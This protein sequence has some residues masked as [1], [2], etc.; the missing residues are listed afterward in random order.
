MIN[1]FKKIQRNFIIG[2][3]WL[4][5]KIY[6]GY[7]TSDKIIRETIAPLVE[8]LFKEKLIDRWFFIRYTDPKY[9]L[10]IRIHIVDK[11][12]LSDVLLIFNSAIRQYLEDDL[13]SKVQADTYQREIERYGTT[14]MELSEEIFCIDSTAIINLI[15]NLHGT[16][17][18]NTRWLIT[19]K[20]IDALL[21]NFELNLEQKCELL[22]TMQENFGKEF[23]FTKDNRKQFG[24]K[25][26]KHK[27][28]IDGIMNNNILSEYD[29]IITEKSKK[30]K[31]IA[32][33]ILSLK[34]NNILEID[35]SNMLSSYIHM[36]LNRAFRTNQ[37]K[38]ELV[39]Y[40]F[41][42]NYYKS[43]IARQGKSLKTEV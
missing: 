21:T 32:K 33:S 29:N 36:M 9:H 12:K 38:Y 41:L 24:V 11:S 40:D 22:K 42:Y 4:Y 2:D 20:M 30:L 43:Q 25:Y 3:E 5:L 28:E 1:D 35:L 6:T 27:I 10:R 18:E 31:P 34:E 37:R 23:G 26:R 17:T 15:K 14:S 8:Y 7:K 16:E 39:I 13:I 19:M